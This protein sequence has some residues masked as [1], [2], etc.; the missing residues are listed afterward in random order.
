MSAGSL[1]RR[2]GNEFY[3]LA[4]PIYRPL[5]SAF[6]NRAD[7]AE[8]AL[9]RQQVRSGGVVVDAGANIGIYSRFLSA[10]VG[11]KGLVHSFEPERTNFSRLQ[12]A[13]CHVDNVRLNQLAV[14]D[15]T[16]ESTLY[17]S[18]TLN[19]DHRTY[20][21]ADEP[22]SRVTIRSIRLDDYFPAGQRVDLIKM[23]IQGFELHA[24]RGAERVL[25]DNPGISLLL[26]FWP[27]GLKCAGASGA[28]LLH[29]LRSNRFQCF[30]ITNRLLVPCFVPRVN[31]D[32][33]ADYFNLFAQR[34]G[35]LTP[36]GA[37][38]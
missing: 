27:Y 28:E 26:E 3:K 36:T 24:L 16:G 11:S 23:D 32:D 20:P 9:L 30:R 8:R 13:L 37:V 34:R 15:R 2:V 14:S 31:P 4:F 18:E 17:I 10:C 12:V 5:Y 22:R 6:K 7:R 1:A 33:P 25:A 29:F 38:I 19:V 21:T 35:S